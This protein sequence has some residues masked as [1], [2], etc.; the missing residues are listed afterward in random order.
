MSV[1]RAQST[2]QSF[3][4]KVCV[5]LCSFFTMNLHAALPPLD[6]DPAQA[7][8][9]KRLF[10]D[11]RL[12]G[13]DSISC[14]RCH[15]PANG[16]SYPEP[17]SPAYTGSDGFR[18]APTLINAAYKEVWFHDGRIG[19]N[20][21]DVVR[22][23]ITEDWLMNM[24]MRLM[25]ERLKQDPI[26]VEMFKA[27]NLGEPSNG[28]VRKAL[29][30]YLKTLT[31]KNVPFDKGELSDLAS[32]GEKLFTG[33]AGCNQC[34]RGALFSDGKAHNTGVPENHEIFLDPMRHQSFLAYNM[35]MGVQD[36]LTLKRDVGAHVQT[37]KADGS[38]RGK[39]ITPTLRE[40]TQTAPYM[41]NGMLAT[42]KD[43]VEFYNQGGGED[44]KKDSRLTTLSLTDYEKKAL[45][46]FLES[47]S[48]DALIGEEYEWLDYD[49]GYEYT[50]DWSNARN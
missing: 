4:R 22:E 6:I 46:A 39:F 47:L 23:N 11:T 38:D 28:G 49:F 13:D 17:L 34:H 1:L 40:L 42:L 5:V 50:E 10:F 26:Y 7:E 35:F 37:H 43:V 16:F 2:L 19:T 36:Y 41:H 9:G 3:A 25:Q 15:I 21:N 18:N 20:L 33:K 14:S 8:L 31:S 12:S 32:Q 48:G 29:P 44:S 24:D 27:A 45:V 30:E